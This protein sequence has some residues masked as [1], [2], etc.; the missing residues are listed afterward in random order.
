M[1][2]FGQKLFQAD[3]I[4][5]IVG[6]GAT[7]YQQMWWGCLNNGVALVGCEL[8][9]C[10]CCSRRCRCRCHAR[11]LPGVLPLCHT[12]RHAGPRAHLPALACPAPPCPADYAAAALIDRRWYGRVRMQAVGFGMLALLFLLM[13]ALYNTLL[14]H[15]GAFQ[16]GRRSMRGELNAC[17]PAASSCPTTLVQNPPPLPSSPQQLLYYLATLFT[18][19][20]PNCVTFLVAGEVRG[21]SCA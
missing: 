7:I 15:T 11:R 9:L 3:F 5:L 6:P 18:Q 14:D 10:C 12:I 16:V 21:A 17:G 19:L 4:A 13:A 20:G 8:L 2:F 1:Q